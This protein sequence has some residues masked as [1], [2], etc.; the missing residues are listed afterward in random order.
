MFRLD[1]LK[2]SY[3][4]IVHIYDLKTKKV[5][6]QGGGHFDVEARRLDV[7]FDCEEVYKD[8]E[9]V[10][11]LQT[12]QG[13]FCPA[14]STKGHLIG[15]VF[16]FDHRSTFSMSSFFHW[17]AELGIDHIT[18]TFDAVYIEVAG[19]N[20]SYPLTT[21]NDKMKTAEMTTKG[22]FKD[23]E[24]QSTADLNVAIKATW[25]SN[26]TT[27]QQKV[28]FIIK[29]DAARFCR[30]DWAALAN[31]FR[32]YWLFQHD[33]T[34]CN[35]TV[36]SFGDELNFVTDIMQL[37]GYDDN[38]DMV[39]DALNVQTPMNAQLLA[40][41]CDFFLNQVK[42][43]GHGGIEFGFYRLLGYR[44]GTGTKRIGDDLLDLVFGL[45]GFCADV[46]K[47]A[48]RKLTKPEKEA[49]RASIKQILE[50][51]EQLKDDLDPR[52][53]EFYNKPADAIF[54]SVARKP[55]R[56]SVQQCF[57]TLGMDFPS[58]EDTVLAVD[59]VRQLFVHGKGYD[60]EDLVKKI[61]THGTTTINETAK[62]GEI[63]IVW[64]QS[65]GLSEKYYKMVRELFMCYFIKATEDNNGNR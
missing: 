27:V 55:Y 45:D 10:P 42:A 19:Q 46:N 2:K 30:T 53:Y 41:T 26:R 38:T 3:V 39:G 14:Q 37:R 6:R 63:Q 58:H 50:S 9:W 17:K 20:G 32:L 52:V 64:G 60:T 22:E 33:R 54:D 4:G 12:E 21:F 49:V 36:F 56:E 61:Y 59:K 40:D 1:T 48:Q 34:N 5:L 57:D 51:I 18:N 28:R 7:L 24:Q 44:F 65:M 25:S 15:S 43:R 62:D 13:F 16:T 11:I 31:A 47:S 23:I 29:A 8:V 35:T